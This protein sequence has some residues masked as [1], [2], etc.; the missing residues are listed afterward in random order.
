MKIELTPQE[1]ETYFHTSL[2]NALSYVETGYGLELTYKESDYDAAKL[3]VENPCYEDVL[4]QILRDGGKLKLVDHECDGEFTKSITLAD[5]HDRVQKTDHRHL[6][7]MINEQDDAV[8]GDVII[9][10]VFYDE[11]I[12]G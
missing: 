11:V 7:D 4:M 6:L 3:K 12:F 10:Q 5:V 2:C 8:T 1:S 9:Q